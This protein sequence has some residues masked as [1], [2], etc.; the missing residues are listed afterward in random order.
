ML[1]EALT[2]DLDDPSQV[3]FSYSHSDQP[4][5]RRCLIQMVEWLSGQ[6]LLRDIYLDWAAYGRMP[7]EPVFDAA[8]RLLEVDLGIEGEENIAA[9]PPEGGLLLVANHPFGILDGLTI[10]HLGMRLRGNVRIMTHSLLCRVPETE[11]FLLPVD[12]SNTPEARRL[13]GETRR[14][15]VDLLAAGKVVAICPAGGIATANRPIRGRAV[16]SAWHPF[17]GRLATLPGVT[18]LPVHFSGQNSRLF[19]VASHLSYPMRLALIF[20]ETRRRMGR[21]M[22]L[23]VGQPIPARDL[24]TIDRNM[25]AETLRQ[26]TMALDRSEGADPDEIFVWPGHIRF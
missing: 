13:T 8:L 24:R 15:A 25:L 19:Q 11:P 20:H 12:F 17:V 5:F 26:R 3:A 6:P 7:G 23:K 9:V 21:R 4:L 10:G 16:D 18:T 22:T 14:R 2:L 1:T